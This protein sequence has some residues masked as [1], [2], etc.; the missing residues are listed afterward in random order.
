[1][2]IAFGW[3]LVITVFFADKELEGGHCWMGRRMKIPV[4][5]FMNFM[6]SV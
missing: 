3:I 6:N 4:A 2:C 5:P 1:M